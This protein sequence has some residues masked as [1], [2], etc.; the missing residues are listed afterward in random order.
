M[1]CIDSIQGKKERNKEREKV[2][3]REKEREREKKKTSTDRKH[4]LM[5]RTRD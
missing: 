3:E 1:D 5:E 2:R 4:L